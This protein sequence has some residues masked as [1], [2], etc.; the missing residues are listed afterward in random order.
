[1]IVRD[2]LLA[3]AQ[4]LQQL[5]ATTRAAAQT[6]DVEIHRLQAIVETLSQSPKLQERER[7]LRGFYGFAKAAVSGYADTRIVLYDLSGRIVFATNLPFEEPLSQTA[8]SA[9]V[10]RAAETR[11]SAVSDLFTASATRSLSLAILVPVI[12]NDAV[13]FVLGVVFSPGS[14]SQIFRREP[15]PAGVLGVVIDRNN[16][17]LAR[18]QSEAQFI[19]KPASASFLEA[20]S[21]RDEGFDRI[22]FP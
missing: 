18:T 22:A 11:Q 12:E 10:Q 13:P 9:T 1:M 14:V 17:I 5:Q 8:I 2:A 21:D 6:V 7:D 16:I 20:I 4:Y 15:F 19:G 3:H